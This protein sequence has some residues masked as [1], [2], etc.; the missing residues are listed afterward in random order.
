MKA[1]EQ[2]VDPCPWCVALCRGGVVGLLFVFA[3]PARSEVLSVRRLRRVSR[4]L[5]VHSVGVEGRMR[6][7]I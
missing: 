7:F 6:F 3:N 2:F 1:S 5:G 4:L